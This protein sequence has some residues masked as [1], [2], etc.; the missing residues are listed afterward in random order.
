MFGHG[1]T[2][3][4]RQ[5]LTPEEVAYLLK[6]GD[7]ESCANPGHVVTLEVLR[8]HF[9]IE[10]PVPPAPPTIKLVEP[11]DQVLVL[12]LDNPK[13]LSERREYTR[14]EVLAAGLSF[15]IYTVATT[16]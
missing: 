6:H 1:V 13:R 9:G 11:G 12:G 3:I 2:G 7:F 14:D 10:V 4:Y 16:E 8:T 5:P 15:A